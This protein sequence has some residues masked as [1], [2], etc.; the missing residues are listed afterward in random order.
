L[1]ENTIM[2]IPG[3]QGFMLGEHDYI[4][5]R[6]MYEESMRM[7]FFCKIPQIYWSRNRTDAIINNTDFAPNINWN[8][9]GGRPQI[10]CKGIVLKLFWKQGRTRWLAKIN[11]LSLLDAYGTPPS[12]SGPTLELGQKKY[13]LIFSMGSIMWIT[14]ILRQLGT[15]DSWGNDF[16][17]HTPP[18]WEFYDLKKDP[19]EIEQCLRGSC[20]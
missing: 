4:D 2:S 1:L 12:K 7:P 9:R 10:I 3:T 11:I 15:K 19:Q 6:W 13:K 8:G 5:K 18:A 14:M 16:A 20:V 17:N